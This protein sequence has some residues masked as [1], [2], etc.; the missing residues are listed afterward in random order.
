MST[1][2]ERRERR[3]VSATRSAAPR[4]TPEPISDIIW[5]QARTRVFV[6]ASELDL[7]TKLHALQV[8]DA[9][10]LASVLD[11]KERAVRILCDALVAMG[12]LV[13]KKN[14]YALTPVSEAFLVDRP[15]ESSW[16]NFGRVHDQLLRPRWDKLTEVVKA[17]RPSTGVDQEA[18]G[19]EFFTQLIHLIYPQSFMAAQAAARRLGVGKKLRGLKI[20]DVAA[21]SGAWGLAFAVED[22]SARV[23]VLDWPE[24][25]EHTRKYVAKHQAEAQY[26]F[27]AGNVHEVDFGEA[28]YDLVI[29]GHICHSE[30]FENTQMLLEKS[31]RALKKDG[32]LLIAEFLRNDQHS[33]PLL[34]ALFGVNMLVST[35]N[36]DTWSFKEFKGWL[37]DL[38]FRK[39]EKLEAPAPS[40]LIVA[41]K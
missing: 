21:G 40:P 34:P 8:A 25:L 12:L 39:V 36:G 28:V 14:G 13:R 18:N 19:P 33:G 30:G 9:A 3:S 4:V 7:F 41:R 22:R 1:T 2:L 10:G 29:L 24:V 5:A 17:G 27:Q 26:E 6:A 38:G 23:T 15:G 35:E 31:F 20:L 11:A 32:R 16:A 37:T